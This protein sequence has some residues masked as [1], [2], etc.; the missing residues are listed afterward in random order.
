[1]QAGESDF[2]VA[3]IAATV[4]DTNGACQITVSIVVPFSKLEQTTP[5]LR[6][7]VQLSAENI[8]TRLGWR[9]P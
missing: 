5:D 4:C 2:S 8:E 1:M 7:L 3:C 9:K 6:Q